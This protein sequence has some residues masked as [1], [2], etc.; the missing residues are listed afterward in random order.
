MRPEKH[1]IKD[2]VMESCFLLREVLHFSL[3]ECLDCFMYSFTCFECYESIASILTREIGVLRTSKT[4]YFTSFLFA[5]FANLGVRCT[6]DNST[7]IHL[8]RRFTFD[9]LS[10]NTSVPCGGMFNGSDS[11]RVGLDSF[12]GGASSVWTPAAAGVVTS[13]SNSCFSD[14]P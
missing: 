12:V 9:R 13:S 11:S 5:K 2:I 3:I 14:S 4:E 8:N 10:D 7:E 1:I 6:F